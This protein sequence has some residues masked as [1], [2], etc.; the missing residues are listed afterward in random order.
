MHKTIKK[1][2]V[3]VI[4]LGMMSLS[5]N[6]MAK[7]IPFTQEDRDRLI[8]IEVKL[9][10]MEKRFEQRFEQMDK[11]FE[12]MDKRFNDMMNF[13]GILA[14]IFTAMTIVTIGFALWDRRTMIRP[15]EVKI[16]EIEE[17]ITE[18]DEDRIEKLFSVLRQ[19]AKTDT[20]V[21]S[22]LKKFSLL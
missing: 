6:I 4:F 9:E 11:R 17:R 22:V 5:Q 12:Q 1:W 21:A 16:K 18:L 19:L 3:I 15:F 10:E 14:A 13:I 7:E 8:R 20:A 2:I